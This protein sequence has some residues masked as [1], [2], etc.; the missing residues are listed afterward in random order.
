MKKKDRS[1]SGHQIALQ[2]EV[3]VGIE[4]HPLGKSID[5]LAWLANGF[6][7]GCSTLKGQLLC[8]KARDRD[9]S[10]ATSPTA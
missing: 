5:S 4:H 8:Q 10:N 9:R 7:C 2:L 6:T 3:T 1:I